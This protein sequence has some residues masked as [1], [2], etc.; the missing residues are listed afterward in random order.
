VERLRRVEDK[1]DEGD[2]EVI[3]Y[4]EGNC[5]FKHSEGNV[6]R[7]IF[8]DDSKIDVHAGR[9]LHYEDEEVILH[10]RLKK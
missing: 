5:S 10:G 3:V 8:K 1:M 4:C 2:R 7:Y 6:I 9:V